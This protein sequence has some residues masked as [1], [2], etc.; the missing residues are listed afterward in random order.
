MLYEAEEGDFIGE[1]CLLNNTNC[2]TSVICKSEVELLVISK[3]DFDA[4]LA[5]AL[6]K[7]YHGTCNFLR[8]LTLFS[9]W[10]AEK[11][12]FLVHCSLRR[13]YRTGTTVVPDSLN[14]YFL[15]VVKS[16]RCLVA[17]Q[18]NQ[19]RISAHS[20]KMHSFSSLHKKIIALSL[21][22]E[23]KDFA[24]RLLKRPAGLSQKSY[25]ATHR[26]NCNQI[27]RRLRPQ[28]AAVSC[29]SLRERKSPSD[30][31]QKEPS[32][33]DDQMRTVIKKQKVASSA[34]LFLKTWALE[35][36]GS[37]GLAETMD[38][39]CGLKFSLISEGADCIFIPQKI[40]LE[41]APDKSKRAAL[42]RAETKGGSSL[43]VAKGERALFEWEGKE[44]LLTSAP[45][46][47]RQG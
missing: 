37:F 35:Q 29:Y 34:P 7:Q 21:L 33:R 4:T 30:L 28:T 11:I 31:E 47:K 26:T 46:Q 12:D 36:E 6:F 17:T 2:L 3:E 10:P 25:S 44:D 45:A 27:P 14:S 42:E 8:K 20:S 23:K 22:E 18:L 41:K 32:E 13:F 40:F 9:S 15:V 19:E 24:W 16:G 1:I 39:F 5:N 38:K 43:L